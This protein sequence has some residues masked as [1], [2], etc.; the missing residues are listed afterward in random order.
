M[1]SHLQKDLEKY[2][3]KIEDLT[4]TPPTSLKKARDA[5]GSSATGSLT[6]A[7]GAKGKDGNLIDNL[8]QGKDIILSILLL[9]RSG[10]SI[11]KTCIN[12]QV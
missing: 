12:S 5:G 11:N 8:G 3:H 9:P 6:S 10:C 7:G 4:G 2:I 1:S